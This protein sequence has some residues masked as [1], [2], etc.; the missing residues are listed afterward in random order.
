MKIYTCFYRDDFGFPCSASS[1]EDPDGDWVRVEDARE[2]EQQLAKALLKLDE[3]I[4]ALQL[5]KELRANEVQ[6]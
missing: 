6:G 2:M 3:C 5:Q 4:E 1:K